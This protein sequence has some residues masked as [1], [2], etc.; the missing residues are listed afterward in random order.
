MPMKK[1]AHLKSAT[2]LNFLPTLNFVLDFLLRL[3]LQF[4]FK[5]MPLGA[6]IGLYPHPRGPSQ[7]VGSVSG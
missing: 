5:Q 1:L 6:T 4:D 2:P 3:I 7:I